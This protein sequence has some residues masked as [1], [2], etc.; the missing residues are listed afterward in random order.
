M[1]KSQ[2]LTSKRLHIVVNKDLS[3]GLKLAQV[4]HVAHEFGKAYPQADVGDTMVVLEAGEDELLF[5]YIEV[6]QDK[7]TEVLG[8]FEPDL[9]NQLT[10]VA[11]GSAAKSK[12]RHLPLAR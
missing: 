3:P 2:P 6:Y 1:S 7:L 4:A 9:N 12:L 11:F 10:A 8:F 5:N